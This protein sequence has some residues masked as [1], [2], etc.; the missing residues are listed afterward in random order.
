MATPCTSNV[1]REPGRTPRWRAALSS[2]EAS[3]RAWPWAGVH[4]VPAV[5]TV[6]AGGASAHVSAYSRVKNQRPSS[7]RA[8]RR[9]T[10]SRVTR[11]PSTA[12]SRART[13]GV[14]TGR[15]PPVRSASR[16]KSSTWSV[17]TSRKKNDGASR[18]CS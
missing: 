5:S 9:S 11:A 13:T 7:S 2:I 17:W 1:R 15:L 3:A 6:P 8:R 4:H 14:K 18:R 12:A 10:T 16:A